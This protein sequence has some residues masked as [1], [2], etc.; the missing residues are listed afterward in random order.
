MW[1]VVCSCT[2][3]DRS[4]GAYGPAAVEAEDDGALDAS[5]GDD[6]AGTDGADDTGEDGALDD[7]GLKLDVMV[8]EEGTAGDG[9][10][11]LGCQSIDV[12]FVVDISA[13]MGEEKD[14]LEANFPSF[15]EVLDGYVADP[16]NGAMS[17]RIGVTN[18]SIVENLDGLSTFGLDGA[19]FDGAGGGGV[20]EECDLGGKL[21][22]DGPADGVAETFQC[23]GRQPKS[24][25]SNCTDI[26]K[27][28]PLDA[29]EMFVAKSAAGEVNAG[30]YRGADSLLVIVV[31][32]DEDDDATNSTTTPSETKSTLDGFAGGEERYVVVAIAGPQ[33]AGCTSAFGEADPAPTLHTFT[34][35]VSN[36]LMGDICLGDLSGALTEA[37]EL[38]QVSCDTLPPVD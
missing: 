9:G 24:G 17:Y 3:Q 12:L 25:C 31:L 37:L 11:D 14:N 27:E 19:L 21:W 33:D 18:S 20:F 5:S 36:G 8:E 1:I 16:D 6:E 22:I 35:M 34:S 32:T 15:V 4:V 29:I 38:I 30:F 28:R 2:V 23:L 10:S 26:G 7:D 13:S